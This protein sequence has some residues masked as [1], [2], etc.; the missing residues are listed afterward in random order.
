MSQISASSAAQS[1]SLTEITAAVAQLD[2]ITQQNAAMVETAV[3]QAT[4]LQD[5]ADTLAESVAVITLQ[6]GTADTRRLAATLPKSVRGCR[7]LP[8][9]MVR[10]CSIPSCG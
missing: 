7:T 3:D 9:S 10:V 1:S 4:N 6:Q 8:V 2:K 5:R